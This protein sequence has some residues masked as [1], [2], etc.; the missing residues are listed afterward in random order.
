MSKQLFLKNAQYDQEA[1][2]IYDSPETNHDE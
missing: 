1:I 2:I